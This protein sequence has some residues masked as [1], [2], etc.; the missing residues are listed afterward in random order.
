M[1][2]SLTNQY[3]RQPYPYPWKQKNACQSEHNRTELGCHTEFL[4]LAVDN[5]EAEIFIL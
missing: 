5:L 4:Q 1:L 2:E 3:G